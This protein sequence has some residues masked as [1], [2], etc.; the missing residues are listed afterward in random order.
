M[1]ICLYVYKYSISMCLYIKLPLHDVM[2]QKMHF[3]DKH[4]LDSIKPY[5]FRQFAK[6][7]KYTIYTIQVQVSLS[8]HLTYL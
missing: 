4:S 5:L 6:A 3:H 7:T 8:Y 2:F 1:F